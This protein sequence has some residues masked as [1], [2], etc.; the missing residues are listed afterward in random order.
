MK[1]YIWNEEFENAEEVKRLIVSLCPKEDYTEF[2]IEE[3]VAK[4]PNVTADY[5]NAFTEFYDTRK[6]GEYWHRGCLCYAEDEILAMQE[7]ARAR[8][9]KC[10]VWLFYAGNELEEYIAEFNSIDAE[11]EAERRANSITEDVDISRLI[12]N[13]FSNEKPAEELEESDPDEY[14]RL[15]TELDEKVYKWFDELPLS[16]K[17]AYASCDW[18]CRVVE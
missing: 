9:D 18:S 6:F 5:L 16:E 12:D 10:K 2:E 4:F 3:A 11:N 17:L 1:I 14:E 8:G 13:Y 7:W 15:W